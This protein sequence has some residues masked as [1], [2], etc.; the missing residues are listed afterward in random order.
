MHV[1]RHQIAEAVITGF[2]HG[3]R[4][5]AMSIDMTSG[6]ILEQVLL[7]PAT[8]AGIP[9]ARD[10]VGAPARGYGA[11]EFAVVVQ[12]KGDV[13]RGMAFATMTQCFGQIGASVPLRAL[14][15]IGAEACIGID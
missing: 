5:A 13:A 7:A 1:V 8:D 4:R 9:V 3:T 15:G 11:R 6:K 14:A 10:V 12:R 2:T